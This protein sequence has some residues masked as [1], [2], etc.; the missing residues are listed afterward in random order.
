MQGQLN[1][2]NELDVA[3]NITYQS[4][5]LSGLQ[6]QHRWSKRYLRWSVTSN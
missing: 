2:K 4:V 1:V 6:F 3:S 5:Y